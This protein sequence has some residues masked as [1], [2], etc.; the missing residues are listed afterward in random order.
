MF[1]SKYSLN[2]VQIIS[3]LEHDLW[4]GISPLKQEPG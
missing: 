1:Q 3:A 4:K 2:D